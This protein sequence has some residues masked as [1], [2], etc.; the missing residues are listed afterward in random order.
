MASS[1][2]RLVAWLALVAGVGVF[3]WQLHGVAKGAVI[4]QEQLSAV[5]LPFQVASVALLVL[6]WVD[7]FPNSWSFLPHASVRFRR[8]AFWFA[9]IAMAIFWANYYRPYLF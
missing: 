1:A 4:P 7:P 9:A 6:F 3:I 5:T 8:V 2:L